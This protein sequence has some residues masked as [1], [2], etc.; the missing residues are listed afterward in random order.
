MTAMLQF[1]PKKVFSQL[2]VYDAGICFTPV[3]WHDSRWI[4]VVDHKLFLHSKNAV[5]KESMLKEH[6]TVS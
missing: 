3:W 4:L 6:N 5:T 1:D 2:S